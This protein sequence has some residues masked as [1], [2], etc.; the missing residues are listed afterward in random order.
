[1]VIRFVYGI[2][3][4]FV[5]IMG[6]VLV[7][8]GLID[9]NVHR[10]TIAEEVEKATGRQ[11]EIRGD[12]GLAIL[13]APRLSVADVRLANLEGSSSPDMARLE[14]LDLRLAFWP[15][16]SGRVVVHSV[17]LRGADILLERLPDG[18][19]NWH[20]ATAPVPPGEA[21][22]GVPV[23]PDASGP[24]AAPVDPG[25]VR[26]EQLIIENGRLVWRD[27]VAGSEQRIEALEARIAADSLAGPFS[28]SGGLVVSGFP[29]R[30]DLRTGRLG[31]DRPAS[32]SAEVRQPDSRARMRLSGTLT[33]G[34]VPAFTGQFDSSGPDLEKTLALVGRM[35]DGIGT[36]STGPLAGPFELRARI[37]AGPEAV[38]VH[39]LDLLLAENRLTGAATLSL[40][41]SPDLSLAL[42]A[43][44]L[45][46]DA[47]LARLNASVAAPPSPGLPAGQPAPPAAPSAAPP[48]TVSFS[49]PDGISADVDL[50]IA[51]LGLHGGVVNDL[52][53][54]ASLRNGIVTLDRFGAFLPG[55]NDIV[56]EGRLQAV[57]GKPRIDGRMALRADDFRALLHWAGVDE[58]RI[59]PDRLRRLVASARIAGDGENFDISDIE[60]AFDSSK[61]D[62]AVAVALRERPGLGI[63][64]D[65]DR[66][67]L[68]AYLPSPAAPAGAAQPLR[69]AAPGA[70]PAVPVTPQGTAL[71]FDANLDIRIGEA[72]WQGQPIRG[73]AFQGGLVGDQLTIGR[74]SADDLVGAR[75][76]VEGSVAAL[77]ALPEPDIRVKLSSQAPLRLAALAGFTPDPALAARLAALAPLRLDGAISARAAADGAEGALDLD[78]S[79]GDMRLTL[80]GLVGGLPASPRAQMD[81]DLN[82]PDF[83]R[84]LRLFAPEYRPLSPAGGPL[85]L[86]ARLEGGGTDYRLPRLALRLGEARLEGDAALALSGI[87]PRLTTRLEGD[88]LVLDRLL[89]GP[90]ATPAGQPPAARPAPSGAPSR[91]TAPWSDDPIDLQALRLIDGRLAFK[92]SSIAYRQ[93]TVSDPTVDL[94]LENGTLTLERLDGR[95][96]GGQF[97][98][99]G[100]LAAPQSPG[101]AVRTGVEMRARAVDLTQA[102]FNAAALDVASGTVDFSLD[103]AGRGATSRALVSSLDGG[104]LLEARDG[105]VRGFDLA[106]VNAQLANLTSP[107]AFLGLA[108]AAMSGG[109]TRFSDLKGRFTVKDGVVRSDDLVL[110]A[111]GGSGTG[112][113]V[114]DLPAWEIDAS[115]RFTLA[116]EAKAPPFSLS[117]TGP[118][119]APRRVIDAQAIQA[120][121]ATRAA[122]SL[123]DTFLRPRPAPEEAPATEAPAPEPA[124]PARPEPDPLMRGIFD[125][126]RQR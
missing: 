69:S 118:L 82:H 80:T 29:L 117:L 103:L 110:T 99:T 13:P 56:V 120:W 33:L 49:L 16:F 18:R 91:G 20:F 73:I 71:P 72:V 50:A 46:L 12:V 25:R 15:L 61:I 92:A 102:M 38:T 51:T 97:A 21:P 9:W 77:F 54:Q 101:D 39:D 123:I 76:A 14:A 94:A 124:P 126:L 84:L 81:L 106:R 70:R 53:L 2:L 32:V 68:D 95:M 10:G 93:W 28:A 60:I 86:A 85:H 47:M 7:V 113:L 75:V 17:V 125:L 122:G 35:G 66:I 3:A 90:A 41:E 36:T 116:S 74:L 88:R 62:G 19:E 48:A 4:F 22:P 40:G 112:R 26:L 42:R 23:P 100:H 8:P 34:P 89:P 30:V 114:I 64:L 79:A 107:V 52:S 55:G 98:M 44:R 67:A 87:R 43:N 108:Q 121:L 5:L 63:R 58:S 11:L 37:E 59:A 6:A 31:A 83:E 78:L 105:A 109:T 96:V 119:D 111:D 45:D 1:M 104:G 115:A 24:G 27:G 65:L 57:S